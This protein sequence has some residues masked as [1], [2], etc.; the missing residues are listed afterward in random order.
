MSTGGWIFLILAWSIIFA[1]VG[2]C[3]R[4]ILKGGSEYD[5]LD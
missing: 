2:F 5:S 3:F 1:I 4:I